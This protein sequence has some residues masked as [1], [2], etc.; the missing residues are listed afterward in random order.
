M[1]VGM[2]GTALYLTGFAIAENTEW[3]S[4]ACNAFAYLG[5]HTMALLA[6]HVSVFEGVETIL[7]EMQIDLGYV[8]TLIEVSAAMAC[9][10]ILGKVIEKLG[11]KSEWINLLK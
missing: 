11:C 10:I 7:N 9:G 1:I 8:Q 5:R 3:L 6:T 4:W 2:T